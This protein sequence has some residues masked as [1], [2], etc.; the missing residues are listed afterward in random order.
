MPPQFFQIRPG[1]GDLH[2]RVRSLTRVKSR[3]ESEVM[4]TLFPGIDPI[5]LPAP[6]WLF[7][8]LHH[9]TLALHF[10]AVF[11]LLGGLGLATTFGLT[12]RNAPGG[13]GAKAARLIV[14]RLPTVMAY[15]VNFGIPPLLFAQ[16][17]Y[18]RALYTSSVLIGA[19]WIG[20]IALVSASYFLIYFAASR[21]DGPR[22]WTPATAITFVLV[23]LVAWIY[24][25]NMS[26]ML[27]PES[28]L[29]RTRADA[30]GASFPGG[31]P[32]VLPRWLLMLA[33]GL[34]FT[35]AGLVLLSRRSSL[36][37]DVRR[38]LAT[39]GGLA[40]AVGALAHAALGYWAFAAQPAAVRE[41]F[42]QGLLGPLAGVAFLVL[43]VVYSATGA[44][45]A[46]RGVTS[47]VLGVAPAAI[48]SLAT[49]ALVLARSAVRDAALAVAGFA[50]AER[51]VEANW[52]VV[53][54]FLLLFVLAL[55]VVGWLMSVLARARPPEASHARHV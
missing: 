2:V 31:D 16:V 4:N 22:R 37:E 3:T 41:A 9:V 40:V 54:L 17:L 20:V 49:V 32:T 29:A 51:A 19:L 28:W 8:I 35:G 11:L 18:G 1:H 33:G 44:V 6:V 21:L 45:A 53:G 5:P 52:S 42:G 23:A 25:T 30:L 50:V 7:Q 43:A 38:Y 27:R 46:W 47:L 55:G 39:R 12:N 14:E 10:G 15:V 34:A 24:S 48:G 13:S 36:G 26:L